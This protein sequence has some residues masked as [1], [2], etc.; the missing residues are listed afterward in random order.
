MP[1][2]T[3]IT[4]FFQDGEDCSFSGVAGKCNFKQEGTTAVLGDFKSGVNAS[5]ISVQMPK[6]QYPG[7]KEKMMLTVSGKQYRVKQIRPR[8][9]GQIIEVDLSVNP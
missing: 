8:G 3:D 7:M 4:I 6:T 2:D 5:D 9:D 1:Q